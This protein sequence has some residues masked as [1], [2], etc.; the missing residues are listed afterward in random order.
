MSTSGTGGPSAIAGASA[1]ERATAIHRPMIDP[2]LPKAQGLYDP[3]AR[4]RCLRRRLR[5]RR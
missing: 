2:G 4:A 5:R 3:T 1:A